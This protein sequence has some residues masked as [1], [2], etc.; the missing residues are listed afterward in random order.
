VANSI[1]E[2]SKLHCNW[3]LGIVGLIVKN[4]VIR[5]LIEDII[6]NLWRN[7]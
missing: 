7:T 4:R 3:K 1:K 2:D 5:D 6:K